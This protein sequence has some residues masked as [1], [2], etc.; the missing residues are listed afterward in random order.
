MR[1]LTTEVTAAIKA[2][3]TGWRE[4]AAGLS[5]RVSA[6]DRAKLDEYLT[7]VR[8]VERRVVPMR[9]E[10]DAAENRAANRNEPAV[11]MPRP[12]NGLPED[13]REHMRLM[14]DLIAIG[15]QTDKTRIATLLLCRDISGLF[16]PFLN[17]ECAPRGVAR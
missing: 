14:C 4:E 12:D 17:G 7:S 13:I 8:E 5:K 9:A 15:F 6:A 2:F 3:W 10:K 11:T 16:Y 1:R